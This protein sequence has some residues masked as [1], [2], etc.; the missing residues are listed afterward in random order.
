MTF[1]YAA[2][3]TGAPGDLTGYTTS[4]SGLI[5]NDRLKQ[6]LTNSTDTIQSVIYTITPRALET[7]CADGPF[8]NVEVKVHPRPIDTVIVTSS[9]S[10]YGNAEGSLDLILAK[11]T[12]P[13]EII[14]DGPNQYHSVGI[15]DIDSLFAGLYSVQVTDFLGCVADTQRFINSPDIIPGNLVPLKKPPLNIA[16]ISCIGGSDGE[17]YFEFGDGIYPPYNYWFK[18]PEGDTI[19]T[20]TG[21]DND[22]ITVGS[23]YKGTYE[24]IVKDKAGCYNSWQKTLTEPDPIDV[25]LSSPVYIDPYN[26]SCNGYNDGSIKVDTVYGGNRNYTY[27]WTGSITGDPTER[28]QS[29]LIAGTYYLEITDTLGCISTDSIILIEP[30]GIE[31]IDPVLSVTADGNYNISCNGSSDGSIDITI[32]GGSGEYTFKWTG[33]VGSG[34]DTTA[35]DQSGITA[36]SYNVQVTDESGCRKNYPFEL[37]EPDSLEISSI[38]STSIDGN[39]NINCSGGNDGDIDITVSGGSVGN[40]SYRWSTTDG[41]GLNETDEDQTGLTAGSYTVIVVDLNGC[42]IEMTYELTEPEPLEAS[43]IGTDITCDPGLDD[44]MADLAVTGGTGQGTYS[45]IWSNG[46]TTEDITGLVEDIYVV[47]VT[48]ENNCTIKDSVRINLPPPLI[49]S[50]DSISDYN[51]LNISC[52]GYM[53]G[54]IRTSVISGTPAYSYSWTGPD[55]FIFSDSVIVNLG[56]GIYNL[57][58]VDSRNCMCDTTIELTEPDSLIMV[59]STS[60]SL[61]GGYNLNCN[62]DNNATIDL[63]ISGG[64]PGYVY[65]WTTGEVTAS[66]SMLEAGNYPVMVRDQNNCSIDSSISITQPEELSVTAEIT[67]AYCPDLPNGEI[68]L[69]VTGGAVISGYTYQWL[70]NATTEYN[71]DLKADVYTVLITDDN[72]CELR[73]TF[74]VENKHSVCLWIPT[75]FSPNGDNINDTWRIESI[76]L[77]PNVVIEIFN[78]WGELVFRSDKGYTNPWDG[79]FKGRMLPVDSYHYVINLNEGTRAVV[80]NVTIV[81]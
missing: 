73:D 16:N 25:D 32:H 19:D 74:I 50:I 6:N 64:T 69:N 8:I 77:Y 9:N 31:L 53:D 76:E 33:P 28:D 22:S 36:G 54:L 30:D 18:N 62:G 3:S 27:F 41:S 15:E 26:I 72:M 56:A 44:G 47:T 61:V 2:E 57:H 75:G 40:Y 12:G 68:T 51:D 55:G 59:V 80:G 7:G 52:Y 45:F 65:S 35:E 13:F 34:I 78:R 48:D 37:T 17:V 70:N 66:L 71:T 39:F 38:F 24:M 23:L 60:G 63:E 79:T 14:W 46:E 5:N 29:N 21:N 81:K 49:L 10:C 4:D 1:D 11:G 20:G 58:V 42:T 67:P 43:F